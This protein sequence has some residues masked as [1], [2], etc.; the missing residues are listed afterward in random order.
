MHSSSEAMPT[1]LTRSPTFS[2][3]DCRLAMQEAARSVRSFLHCQ[4]AVLAAEGR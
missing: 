4:A 3:E 2:G 1:T